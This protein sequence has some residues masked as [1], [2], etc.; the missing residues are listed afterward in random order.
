MLT[1]L[2]H[3]TVWQQ[4]QMHEE[5]RACS[6]TGLEP[7]L[8]AV[9]DDQLAAQI[10][11]HAGSADVLSLATGCPD[12][13][14]KEA[15]LVCLRDADALIPHTDEHGSLL[16]F[17]AHGHLDLPALRAVLNG[18]G[19]QVGKH[20]LNAVPVRPD[21][22]LGEGR[23]FQ[24]EQKLMASGTPLEVWPWLSKIPMWLLS[25]KSSIA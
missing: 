14:A 18:I 23:R 11:P 2:G 17:L 7:D 4:W 19:E 12:K 16:L 6:F 8:P 20:L 15:G 25:R 3:W 13:P 5:H 22:D 1:A 10:E 9:L 21:H 24:A